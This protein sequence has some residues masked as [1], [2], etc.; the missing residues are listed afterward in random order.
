M[1]NQ[2][3]PFLSF[4]EKHPVGST[5]K[6]MVESYSSHGAYVTLGEA[7]GYVPLRLMSDPPPRS[8]REMMKLGES[9]DLVVVSFNA[10]RRSID[11]CV[12]GME[13]PEVR[14]KAAKPARRAGKKAAAAPPS[15][16]AAA[17]RSRKKAAAVEPSPPPTSIPKDVSRSLV[18]ETATEM[19]EK[20]AKRARQAPVPARAP[21]KPA[22]AKAATAK[23]K[24]A[25]A[26]AAPA[27]AKTPS[28][29]AKV[30]DAPAPA[31]RSRKKAAPAEAAAEPPASAPAKRARKT[32]ATT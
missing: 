18:A 3:L 24:A 23:A 11:L 12:P 16:P 7:R 5:V 22:S 9:V 8:A 13:P 17:K 29:P 2:L 25:G 28:A 32:A 10:T 27:P 6:G 19:R 20:P 14:A 21:A 26:K 31:K 15:E 4:V 1:V 30:K